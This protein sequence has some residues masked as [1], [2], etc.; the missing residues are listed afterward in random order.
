M[1]LTNEIHAMQQALRSSPIGVD[2]DPRELIRLFR[3]FQEELKYVKN[4]KD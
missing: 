2:R 4:D 1:I 3:V